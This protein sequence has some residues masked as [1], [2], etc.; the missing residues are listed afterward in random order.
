MCVCVCI[1]MLEAGLYSCKYT[2]A[3]VTWGGGGGDRPIERY[4]R[5]C[6]STWWPCSAQTLKGP[7]LG[8]K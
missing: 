3:P 8:T 1:V 5:Q 4:S 7:F 2:A 6:W